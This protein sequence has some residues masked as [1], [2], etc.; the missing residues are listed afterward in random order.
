ML[1]S[2]VRVTGTKLDDWKIVREPATERY[3]DGVRESKEGKRAGFGK[4]MY[5]R[6]FYPDGCGNFEQ[7]KGT[8]NG[9]LGLPRED[10]DEATRAGI[11]RAAKGNWVDKDSRNGK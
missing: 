7:G 9:L 4:V 3:S 11:E 10:L 2:A 8:L 6:V 1:E 5:T